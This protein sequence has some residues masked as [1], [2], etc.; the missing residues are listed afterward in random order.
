MTYIIITVVLFIFGLLAYLGIAGTFEA[1]DFQNELIRKEVKK[2][3]D[4]YKSF[5]HLLILDMHSFYRD[6]GLDI[7][8]LELYK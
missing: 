2:Y 3:H 5:D 8:F 6:P 1:I 4:K 7:Y